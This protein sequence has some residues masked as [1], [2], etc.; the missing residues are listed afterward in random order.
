MKKALIIGCKGQDGSLLSEYLIGKEYR[1]TG[2]DKDYIVNDRKEIAQSIDLL[3]KIEV[4]A[5]I[6]EVCPDELYY[7]AACHQSSQDKVIN[8]LE[9]FE[10]SFALNVMGLVNVLDALRSSNLLTS[11]FYASSSLVFGEPDIKPQ[12]EDLPLRPE[13]I[14]GVTKTSGMHLCYYYRKKY[15]LNVS[16]GILYN[17]ESILRPENF[18]SKKITSSVKRIK[19]GEQ[20]KIILGDLSAL[21]DWGYAPDYVEAMWKILQTGKPETYI[22]ATGQL[23]SVL[24]WVTLAFEEVGMDWKEYT[25][26]D[27]TLITRSR[28]VLVGNSAK[29]Y[30]DTGWKPKTSFEEMVKLMMHN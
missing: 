11:V 12:T 6:S 30:L 8:D 2:I 22:V 26:E 10:K 4:E 17:H 20:K 16:V 3:N 21:A 28:P 27:K 29:L 9:L 14:Y 1:V 5:L 23:H 7:L 25:I 24:D 13:C 18:L 19:A 15:N